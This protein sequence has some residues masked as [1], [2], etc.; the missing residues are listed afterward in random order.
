MNKSAFTCSCALIVLAITPALA[1]SDFLSQA[2]DFLNTRL[3]STSSAARGSSLSNSQIAAGLK[4]A[5]GIGTKNVVSRLS[6]TGGFSLDPKIHIPLPG[7][8]GRA[9]STLNAM[10]F[11][12]MT[13][14]L[15]ARM[16]RAAELAIPKAGALFASSIQKMTLNDARS[17]LSGQND[18]ATQYLKKT[19]ST[20]LAKDIQPI[21]SDTLAQAGAV[22]A[23]DNVMG[24]YA[25]TPLASSAKTNLNAYVTQ[26]TMDGVFYYMAKEEA[27]IRQDPAKQTTALLK[28]V[29]GQK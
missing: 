22:K 20:D 18:A 26:K 23:Y 1:K 2:G 4:E 14:D 28:T 9:E 24:K 13:S 3:S 17:I 19:T 25:A 15:D 16:N 21:V 10:G 8:L 12:S 5:L 29:F 27:A 6:K 11:G 7:M